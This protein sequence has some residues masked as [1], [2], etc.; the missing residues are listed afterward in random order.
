[1]K[2]SCVAF[3]FLILPGLALAGDAGGTSYE[4]LVA[5]LKSGNTAID[6]RRCATPGPRSRA[7]ILMPRS[8]IPTKAI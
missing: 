5:Q 1:M 8:P 6:Y 4:A 2:A 7:T 3:L